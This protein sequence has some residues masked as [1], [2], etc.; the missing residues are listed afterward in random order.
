M[1]TLVMR[2]A[3]P[4]QSWGA[5]S[6][7]EERRGTMREPTK[8]GVI[9]M[10][11]SALGRRREEAVNDLSGL[12]FG[13]RIDQPG[14]LLRDY[15]TVKSKDGK[16]SYVTNRYYLADAVFLVG[17]EGDDELLRIL[18]KALQSPV[19]PLYLGRRSCPPVGRI[20]LGVIDSTLEKALYGA[21][22]QAGPYCRKRKQPPGESRNLTLVLDDIGVGN[23]RRR[24][25]PVSFSQQHRKYMYRYVDDRPEAVPVQDIL[26]TEHDAFS[27]VGEEMQHDTIQN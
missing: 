10:L 1:S 17:L 5:D 3:A 26:E 15:H 2:L 21:S 22:W 12:S 20:S 7:F 11:A 25:L 8:S 6:K 14:Q 27:A 23:L 16:T 19:F 9:G 4:L 24:D 13:V 18:D